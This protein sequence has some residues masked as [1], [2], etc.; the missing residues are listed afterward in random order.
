MGQTE[1]LNHLLLWKPFDCVQQMNS[2]SW[3]T[4][5]LKIICLQIIPIYVVI[6]PTVVEGD[7]NAPF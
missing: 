1:L 4:C 5:Y 3:K 6:M 2:D 7:P